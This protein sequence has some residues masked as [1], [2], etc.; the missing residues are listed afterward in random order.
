[1]GRIYDATWGRMFS[2]F[3]DRAFAATEEA[4]LREMCTWERFCAFAREPERRRVG[5]DAH[6]SVQGVRYEVDPAAPLPEA[7]EVVARE[8]RRDGGGVG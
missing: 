6:V 1:M 3:Y 7:R 4:G 5:G 8:A 2:A